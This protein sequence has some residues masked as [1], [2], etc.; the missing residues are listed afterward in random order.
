M[1]KGFFSEK[2]SPSRHVMKKKIQSCYILRIGSNK[3]PNYS[4][5]PKFFYFA[6]PSDLLLN[7]LSPLV[8]DRQPTYFTNLRRKKTL[9][10]LVQIEDVMQSREHKKLL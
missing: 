6:P 2:I 1:D 4:R 3:L 9:V 10:A 7:W 5:N 8:R